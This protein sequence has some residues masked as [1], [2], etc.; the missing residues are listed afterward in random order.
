MGV[1]VFGVRVCGAALVAMR[2][3]KS[4]MGVC[5]GGGGGGGVSAPRSNSSLFSRFYLFSI[6]FRDLV[7]F[8]EVI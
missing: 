3:Q 8:H 5:V 2:L 7:L 4:L 1:G 6:T